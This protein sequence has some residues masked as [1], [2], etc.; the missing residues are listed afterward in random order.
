MISTL[1]KISDD[2]SA[3]LITML[4]TSLLQG[5]NVAAALR[6]AQLEVLK[7][8]KTRDPRYWAAF[9]LTGKYHQSLR[10]IQYIVPL[11]LCY[12]IY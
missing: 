11:R 7:D 3:N 12:T 10:R 9:K 2:V 4:Y 8:S 6:K 5:E 1:W